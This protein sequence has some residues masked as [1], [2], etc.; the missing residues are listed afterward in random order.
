[1]IFFIKWIEN[2]AI[3]LQRCNMGGGIMLQVNIKKP[4]NFFMENYTSYLAD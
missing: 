3:I 4:P 2:I 1:M